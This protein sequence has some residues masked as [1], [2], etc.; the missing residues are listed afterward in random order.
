MKKQNDLLKKKCSQDDGLWFLKRQEALVWKSFLQVADL[1][2][3]QLIEPEEY[4]QYLHFFHDFFVEHHE[5]WKVAMHSKLQKMLHTNSKIRIA[6][7]TIYSMLPNV[8][9]WVILMVGNVMKNF[10]ELDYSKLSFF[11]ARSA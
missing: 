8:L 1:I 6:F 4:S 3:L 10:E 11:L 9:H 7:G 2:N 5:K